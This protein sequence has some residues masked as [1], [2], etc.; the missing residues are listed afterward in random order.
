MAHITNDQL[1]REGGVRGRLAFTLGTVA[2]FVDGVGFLALFGLFITHMSGNSTHVGVGVG[3]GVWGDAI[4]YGYPIVVFVI[5]VAAGAVLVETLVRRE[6]R[7][8]LAALLGIE[9]VLLV[10]LQLLGAWLDPNDDLV[11]NTAPFFVLAGVAVTAMGLQSATLRRVGG[12][13][14]HT[15]FI[16]GMLTSVGVELA[17]LARAG[18]G[19]ERRQAHRRLRLVGGVWLA[20][21]S[22]AIAGAFL[23]QHLRLWALAIPTAALVVGTAVAYR[24][25]VAADGADPF[26]REVAPS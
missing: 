15:T 17:T 23:H 4:A 8:S 16:T 26:R 9:A 10:A 13:T 1:P 5:A 11:R 22:G 2:G 6:V 18:R 21:L 20:Y 14:V 19:D 25:R 3:T 7:S 24:R 12:V